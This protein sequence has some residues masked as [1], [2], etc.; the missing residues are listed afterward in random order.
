M[1]LCLPREGGRW[2]AARDLNPDGLLH[3]P[4]KRAR[5]PIPPAAQ[6]IAKHLPAKGFEPLTSWSEAM[7]S[8][9]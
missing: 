7:R 6:A 3:T 5:L 4:L 2:W 8:V 9:R 1:W